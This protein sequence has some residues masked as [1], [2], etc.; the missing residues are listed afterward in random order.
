MKLEFSWQHLEKNKISHFTKILPV[1]AELF[2]ADGRTDRR[3]ETKSLM[4][5]LRK[6][7]KTTAVIPRVLWLKVTAHCVAAGTLNSPRL[8]AEC[9][10]GE[11]KRRTKALIL[12]KYSYQIYF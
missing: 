7:L 10:R 2:H 6:R 11:C 5:T 1:E 8:S 4:A 3:D 9:L 12:Y